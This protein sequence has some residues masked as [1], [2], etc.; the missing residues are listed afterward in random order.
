[1]K[2]LSRA[3]EPFVGEDATFV[4][5]DKWQQQHYANDDP[6]QSRRRAAIGFVKK[7]LVGQSDDCQEQQRVEH[8]FIGPVKGDVDRTLPAGTAQEQGFNYIGEELADCVAE[9]DRI[10]SNSFTLQNQEN[11]SGLQDEAHC[12]QSVEEDNAH[13]SPRLFLEPRGANTG[14]GLEDSSVRVQWN[15]IQ[16]VRCNDG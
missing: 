9:E 11:E 2:L 1:M 13:G 15:R 10:S 12:N 14:A 8:H 4:V 5:Q 3:S 7:G 6:Q 16:T